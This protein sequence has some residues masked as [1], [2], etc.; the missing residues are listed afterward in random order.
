MD[1][2]GKYENSAE[3]VH[4]ARRTAVVLD[5]ENQQERERHAFDEVHVAA[6]RDEHI[7]VAIVADADL[8]SS[9]QAADVRAAA[10]AVF[11]ADRM[12]VVAVGLLRD[13]DERKLEKVLPEIFRLTPT[14]IR[15]SLKLNRPIYQRTASY[16]HFGRAPEKD[17][18]FS[19]EQ[20]NLV[21]QLKSAFK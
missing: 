15:R 19:W 3:A 7:G 12:S 11:R 10:E 5:E 18:G 14:N 16:G 17:G 2:A 6:A 1:D 9:P 13:A 20:T 8:Q 4:Q 21:S